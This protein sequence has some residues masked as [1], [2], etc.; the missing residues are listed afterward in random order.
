MAIIPIED[1]LSAPSPSSNII[2]IA[3]LLEP[4][5]NNIIPIADL[6]G[7]PKQN[8]FISGIEHISRPGAAV[9]SKI[10]GGTFKEGFDDPFEEPLFA[11][12]VG[13]VSKISP[14]AVK[15]FDK[16]RSG[17]GNVGD[18]ASLVPGAAR[19]LGKTALG[20]AGDIATDP[21]SF[22]PL[23]LLT[24]VG[25]TGLNKIPILR[26]AAQAIGKTSFAKGLRKAGGVFNKPLG[27]QAAGLDEIL[28]DIATPIAKPRQL[29]KSATPTAE[30]QAILKRAEQTS[31]A[32]R[33]EKTLARTKEQAVG[34][35]AAQPFTPE[36]LSTGKAAQATLK[37]ARPPKEV[38]PPKKTP[39]SAI[40]KVAKQEIIDTAEEKG[41]QKA[42][43]KSKRQEVGRGARKDRPFT[44]QDKSKGKAAQASLEEA[45]G[46]APALQALPEEN[47][48][49]Q[50]IKKSLAKKQGVEPTPSVKVGIEEVVPPKKLSEKALKKRDP[51]IKERRDARQKVLLEERAE[52]QIRIKTSTESQIKA[53]NLKRIK[54]RAEKGLSDDAFRAKLTKKDAVITSLKSKKK[55]VLVKQAEIERDIFIA[56]FMD[57]RSSA[58]GF[59]F[60][61]LAKDKKGS[62][63][64]F[65]PQDPRRNVIIKNIDRIRAEVKKSGKSLRKVLSGMKDKSGKK[66]FDAVEVER[67][68]KGKP[69]ALPK[70]TAI[71]KGVD[72]P[73]QLEKGAFIKRTKT[74]ERGEVIKVFDD[75]SADIRFDEGVAKFSKKE[76]AK[77]IVKEDLKIPAPVREFGKDTKETIEKLNV[78]SEKTERL[79]TIANDFLADATK[80]GTKINPQT[81]RRLVA[82]MS[83]LIGSGQVSGD[84]IKTLWKDFGLSAKEIGELIKQTASDA[85]RELG[86]FGNV[87]KKLQGLFSKD[88]DVLAELGLAKPPPSSVFDAW[89]QKLKT[90]LQLYQASLISQFGTAARNVEVALGVNS[91]VDI[92]AELLQGAFNKLT[93]S[94]LR[95][96]EFAGADAKIKGLIRAVKGVKSWTKR[97]VL[98]D[99]TQDREFV[100]YQRI[101]KT[102]PFEKLRIIQASIADTVFTNRVT[103]SITYI[104]SAQ[105]ALVRRMAF[106]S[107]LLGNLAK[108]GL[109]RN[110][111]SDITGADLKFLKQHSD[112][113]IDA[114]DHALKI[115]F[116]NQ[117]ESQ[118]GQIL[119]SLGRKATPVGFIQPFLRFWAIS[120][121][122]VLRHHPIQ[123]LE[124]IRPN[125]AFR[126]KLYTTNNAQQAKLMADAAVGLGLSG[127]AIMMRRN[128]D[129]AGPKWYQIKTGTNKKTGEGQF[130]DV[131][132]FFP[133]SAYFF[134][135]AVIDELMNLRGWAPKHMST[136]LTANDWT[137]G[138]TNMRRL[139]STPLALNQVFKSIDANNMDKAVFKLKKVSGNL[140]AGYTT[141]FRQF[142]DLASVFDPKEA[143]PRSV[144]EDPLLGPLKANIPFV[145]QSLPQLTTITRG[146]VDVTFRPIVKQLSGISYQEMSLGEQEYHRLGLNLN[147]KT[148]V[149]GDQAVGARIDRE[150]MN[151]VG[152]IN[153]ATMTI[154]V[155][156]PLYKAMNDRERS[157]TLKAIEEKNKAAYK[158]AT[159]F[160]TSPIPELEAK[161]A[162]D[163]EASIIKQTIK[164]IIP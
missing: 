15:S 126:N 22:I 41:L 10:R 137:E 62:S 151:A 124:V 117:P 31:D 89:N 20:F 83:D 120:T 68:M 154:M 19:E 27:K 56:D 116:A 144:K 159:G 61:K 34:R 26:K 47:A 30:K 121:E 3:D 136:H 142:S 87:Q 107:Q 45:R 1:L 49:Q 23:G 164:D 133:L 162:K 70:A 135:A 36:D 5:Q 111:L 69:I 6:V 104:N 64:L 156:M 90:S 96:R 99:I 86:V 157:L 163:L 82:E 122:W 112:L 139:S 113:I 54:E 80:P 8:A 39:K 145:K 57:R 93:G 52:R 94:G 102:F 106:E 78:T 147:P 125:P 118:V 38:I 160:A 35:P 161:R 85:G 143:I 146:K 24:K 92:V 17:E 11:E 88:A 32:V 103:R 42:L 55:V 152:P 9:R 114:V 72:E 155:Q 40:S 128:P 123:F 16:I 33:L 46:K 110:L 58:G 2:P 53:R 14:S 13:G 29:P 95:G 79:T 109:K 76:I 48:L 148:Q 44:P 108:N 43:A 91:N 59:K 153:K 97:K 71:A 12:T 75:G 140:L 141:F 130:F 63:G 132:P 127:A 18:F 77:E 81:T 105:E 51:R 66:I 21:L 129:L 158:K 25:A 134:Q 67:L 150:I 4:A 7:E 119:V 115:S 100:A 37:K 98:R 149:V 60:G 50:G 65:S 73:V 131:R 138:I 74:G 28:G 84:A 101:L